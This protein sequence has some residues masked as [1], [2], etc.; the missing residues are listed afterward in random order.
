VQS[1]KVIL[2]QSVL[3][4][5]DGCKFPVQL[6]FFKPV[7]QASIYWLFSYFTA[8]SSDTKQHCNIP[9]KQRPHVLICLAERNDYLT[10][11]LVS[12]KLDIK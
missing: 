10:A 12:S 1:Q 5:G 2:F 3:Q 11:Y 8:L 9:E 6:L 4:H 7:P